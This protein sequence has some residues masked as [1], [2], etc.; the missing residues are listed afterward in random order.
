[1]KKIR[2]ILDIL[3]FIITLLLMDI[4]KLGHVPHEFLG[5]TIAILIV[6]HLIL[7][8][9]WMKNITKN[10]GKVKSK[11]RI[12][13]IINLFTFIIY[14]ATIFLGMMISTHIFNFHTN[15]NG[16]LMLLHHILGR[17]A[18][19]IMLVHLGFHLNPMIK[20]F[21]KDETVKVIFY[22]MYIMLSFI[23]AIYLLYTLTESYIWKGI[24]V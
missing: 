18:A 2:V 14:F 9:K 12:Q 11:T 22:I 20:K 7:N 10:L 5:I 16:Y 17:L 1:M 19:I 8:F 13:Y 3:M 21:T 6:L 15:G 23:V 24:M 4:G